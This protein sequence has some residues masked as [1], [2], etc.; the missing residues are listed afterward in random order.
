MTHNFGGTVLAESVDSV[1]AAAVS[2]DGHIPADPFAV[3]VPCAIVAEVEGRV[4]GVGEAVTC[5]R[6]CLEHVGGEAVSG[7]YACGC[8]GFG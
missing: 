7:Q 1:S 2:F 5:Y 8:Y 6:G 4:A 3:F